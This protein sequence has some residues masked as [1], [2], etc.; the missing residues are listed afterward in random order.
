M[1]TTVWPSSSGWYAF[2]YSDYA[3]LAPCLTRQE[4]SAEM[5]IHLHSLNCGCS[6]EFTHC[7]WVLAMTWSIS[8]AWAL[9][10]LQSLWTTLRL[11]ISVCDSFVVSRI[12]SCSS[13]RLISCVLMMCLSH[14]PWSRTLK[15]TLSGH[16]LSCQAAHFFYICLTVIVCV[17][18]SQG[19]DGEL[20]EWQPGQWSSQAGF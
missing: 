3:K 9:S 1:T 5:W 10:S 18:V 2:C 8:P 19:V 11:S 20:F 7:I 12:T 13:L 6:T 16:F 14:I 15:L 4:N 17:S